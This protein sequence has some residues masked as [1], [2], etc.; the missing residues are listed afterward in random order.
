MS[1]SSEE[2]EEEEDILPRLK[3]VF[4]RKVGFHIYEGKRGGRGLE[5]LFR[6]SQERFV[7]QLVIILSFLKALYIS[8]P[9]AF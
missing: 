7:P 6:S 5:Y 8:F 2:E 4:V 1:S 3:P 9:F